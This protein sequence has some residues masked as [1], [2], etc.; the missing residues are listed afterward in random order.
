MRLYEAMFLVDH[1]TARTD[2]AELENHIHGII[3]RFE[4]KVEQSVKWAERKLAYP[5]RHNGK[6][7]TKGAYILVHFNSEP[8]EVAKMDRM[9]RL[10]EQVIRHFIIRDE[11]GLYD[12][13]RLEAAASAEEIQQTGDPDAESVEAEASIPE[14]PS[15]FYEQ[16]AG[17]DD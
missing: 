2:Y 9:F 1:N 4:G 6:V 12:E 17:E 7:Y 8:M 10:S 14:E 5:I 13:S 15:A 11:D 16:D 3:Q